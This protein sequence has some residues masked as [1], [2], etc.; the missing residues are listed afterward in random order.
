MSIPIL[1]MA[2][3]GL[4]PSRLKIA[5]YRSRGARIGRDVRIGP[6][7]VLIA[8]DI[9]IGDG[10]RLGMLSFIK[11][12]Q[13][14]LGNRV[15]IGTLVAIDTGKVS[16]GH[17][18]VIMEQSVVGGM[19]TP[20]SSLSIGCRVKVFPY[21]FL[22]PTEPI[23]IE[24]DVG[25][26]GDTY[27]FTHGSWQSVLDGFP[28][29]FG[30]IHI[31]RGVWLPWRVF[32]LPSV[33][34][35]EHATIAA[36]AVINR[37]IPADSLAAGMPAKVLSENGAYRRPMSAQ[38]QWEKVQAIASEFGEFLAY[39]GYDVQSVDAQAPDCHAM[40]LRSRAGQDTRVQFC[41]AFADHAQADIV[42][43][44]DAIEP[45]H[46]RALDARGAGWFDIASHAAH[47]AAHPVSEEVRN[48]LS[49]YGIRFRIVT[50][51]VFEPL[52]HATGH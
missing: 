3:V 6:L 39:Q 36:G 27:M 38:Q 18:S 7:T 13:L 47:P 41:R 46:I 50:D 21:C 2:L 15:R 52:E 51:P 8:D 32:I 4:L 24:D 43:S 48:Y 9:E 35:G 25:V 42:V 26:G 34:I 12:R 11:A 28:I 16:I 22:N 23:T 30:P 49:R 17:D 5:Y 1:Q 31:R 40:R 44:L 20:R 29:G 10:C 33:E 45:A 37:S 14:R 19:L